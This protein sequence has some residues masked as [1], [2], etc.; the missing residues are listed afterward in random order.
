MLQVTWPFCCSF[1]RAI[2]NFSRLSDLVPPASARLPISATSFL[3]EL[4]PVVLLYY[5]TAV[6]V[7]LPGT[8]EL[9]LVLLPLTLWFAFRAITSIDIA[10]A[11]KEPGFRCLDFGFGVSDLQPRVTS[12][13][14]DP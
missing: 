6:L 13:I 4:L 12:N 10:L 1:R 7:I 5:V 9:R 11:W 2:H 14:M 8:F 3:T